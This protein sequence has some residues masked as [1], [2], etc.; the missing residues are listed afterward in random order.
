MVFMILSLKNNYFREMVFEQLLGLHA[1]IQREIISVYCL[2]MA[3]L[4]C[5]NFKRN[6]SIASSFLVL[7]NA[8]L[9]S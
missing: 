6:S 8:H 9:Q 3:K 1:E 2:A 4:I 5:L 7:K